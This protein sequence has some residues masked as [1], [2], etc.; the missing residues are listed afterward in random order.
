MSQ[1]VEDTIT[2]IDALAKA[3][4]SEQAVQAM[5][6]LMRCRWALRESQLPNAN[7]NAGVSADPAYFEFALMMVKRATELNRNHVTSVAFSDLDGR[8]HWFGKF[9][10]KH[11]DASDYVDVA[12]R[13]LL[14]AVQPQIVDATVNAN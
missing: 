14:L 4:T 1:L 12:A 3:D 7:A 9:D 2:A 10:P 8:S 11:T 13:A 5:Q 6:E